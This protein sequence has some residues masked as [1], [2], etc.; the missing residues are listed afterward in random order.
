VSLTSK[1]AVIRGAN[2]SQCD[3]DLNYPGSK[4]RS[5]SM[6]QRL[7]HGDCERERGASDA[8]AARRAEAPGRGRGTPL[9]MVCSV[10]GIARRTA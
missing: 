7:R 5:R 9:G 4:L 10:L 6:A 8:Q 1:Y 2:I 3:N